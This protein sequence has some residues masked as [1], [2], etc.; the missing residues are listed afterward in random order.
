MT[1]HAFAGK[2]SAAKARPDICERL[3][4]DTVAAISVGLKTKEGR[5]IARRFAADDMAAAAAI[6]RLSE[7]DGI[8][9]PSCVTPCAAVVPVALALAKD[10]DSLFRAVAG[11]AAAGMAI[12]RAIGGTKALAAG[13]W[14]SL[15]AAPAMAAITA[16]I[17]RGIDAEGIAHAIALALTSSDGKVA[18]P[19][20]RWALFAEA[21]ARGVEAANKAET[22]M[23]GDLGM[24]SR[25]FLEEKSGC[26]G[27]DMDAFEMAS[28][29]AEI[30]FK[31]CPIA[32]QGLNA[33]EA[34]R[35]ILK[36]GIDAKHI[37][38]VDVFV[39]GEN[40][41]L[42]TRP[43]SAEHRLTRL[44]HMGF[45]LACAAFAPEKL[46]DAERQ[47]TEA[48]TAFAARVFVHADP[49][50]ESYLPL[51]WPARVTV[52]TPG[53]AFEETVLASELDADAPGLCESLTKKWARLAP[54]Y[55]LSGA[56]IFGLWQQIARRVRMEASREG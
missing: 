31:P 5:D 37:E 52:K 36:Q 8:H 34:F 49:A 40:L 39:P 29:I 33:V 53:L 56:G 6:A 14:P 21:V 54:E 38:S 19:S 43:I 46:D 16:S 48:L 10:E 9:L 18:T 44:C 22:G 11:G 3:I 24:L 51:R 42:L 45:Q 25:S 23:R 41:A 50:L 28:N 4:K 47:A 35:K 27:V 55:D 1:I 12:G 30:G 7:C 20:G 17:A 32:R 2:L 26:G 13:T 15:L